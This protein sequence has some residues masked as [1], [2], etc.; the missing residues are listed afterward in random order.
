MMFWMLTVDAGNLLVV[1][2]DGKIVLTYGENKAVALS[3]GL[4]GRDCIVLRGAAVPQK[5]LSAV[6][7]TECRWWYVLRV[8][9]GSD[10]GC[11]LVH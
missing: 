5:P 9:H 8:K 7:C 1:D 10:A 11:S 2:Q 3:I 4:D 6:R